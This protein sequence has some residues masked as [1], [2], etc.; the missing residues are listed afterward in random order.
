MSTQKTVWDIE[1][2]VA[3]G[4]IEIHVD[5]FNGVIPKDVKSFDE[6]HDYVDANE[7]GL[8]CTEYAGESLEFKIAVQRALNSW[9]TGGMKI[10]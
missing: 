3:M 8:L 9:I 7:Y 1:R 6:L 10:D 5:I 4:K 2:A